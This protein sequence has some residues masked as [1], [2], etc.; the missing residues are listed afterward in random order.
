MSI[1]NWQVQ[2]FGQ[3]I[4]DARDTDNRSHVIQSFLFYEQACIRRMQ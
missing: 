4:S 1:V 2:T 3:M